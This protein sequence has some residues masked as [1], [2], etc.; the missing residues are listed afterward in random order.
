M[1]DRAGLL[2]SRLANHD[3]GVTRAASCVNIK[4]PAMCH[5]AR[6]G[7]NRPMGVRLRTLFDP[8]E[9]RQIGCVRVG[10]GEDI[11][12]GDVGRNGRPVGQVAGSLNDVGS[13]GCARNG[14]LKP[15]VVRAHGR[16]KS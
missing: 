3:G 14:E 4:T 7:G 1:V 11:A 6:R 16:G 13:P 9:F 15:A 8:I 12:R 2:D 5:D 10:V